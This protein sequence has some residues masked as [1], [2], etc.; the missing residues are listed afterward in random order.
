MFSF[1][2]KEA[3]KS[4]SSVASK[5]GSSVYLPAFG[6][7]CSITGRPLGTTNPALVPAHLESFIIQRKQWSVGVALHLRIGR[8]FIICQPRFVR[9]D[10]K[11]VICEAFQTAEREELFQN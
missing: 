11:N 4:I 7:P 2:N 8:Q 6:L 3:E 10:R 5:D 1:P 9:E